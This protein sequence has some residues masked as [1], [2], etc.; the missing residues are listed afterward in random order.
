MAA[1]GFQRVADALEKD[2]PATAQR[3]EELVSAGVHAGWLDAGL[4]DACSS[5]G[6]PGT[7]GAALP[8]PEL[9][10]AALRRDCCGTAFLIA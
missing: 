5:A 2:V 9:K 3:Y 4:A 10:V 1:Q 8:S 6:A 7:G